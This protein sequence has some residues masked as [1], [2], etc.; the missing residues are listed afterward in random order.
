MRTIELSGGIN[1]HRRRFFGG[2]G[3]DHRRRPGLHDR[4]CECTNRQDKAGRCASDFKTKRSG[5]ASNRS[6]PSMSSL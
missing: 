4:G 6:S 2:R 1:C 5:M 3:G